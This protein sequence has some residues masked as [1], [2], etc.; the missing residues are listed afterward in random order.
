[1][2]QNHP[3]VPLHRPYNADSSP[4]GRRL[5]VKGKTAP[6]LEPLQDAEGIIDALN[7]AM[8]FEGSPRKRVLSLLHDFQKLLHRDG[9]PYDMQLILHN[10][11]TRKEGPMIVERIPTGPVLDRIEPRP[12]SELQLVIDSA[13]PVARMIIPEA[14]NHVRTPRAYIVSEDL[15]VTYRGWWEREI[16]GRFLR[17][18]GWTDLMIAVWASGPDSMLGLT[19]YG[20]EGMPRFTD[21]E[22]RLSSLMLRAAAP[23]LYREF[24]D[25]SFESLPTRPIPQQE[26][27]RTPRWDPMFGHELSERQRDVLRLLLRGLS[28]KEAANEL[29]VS[30]HTVHTHVKRLYA[31]FDVSSRGELLALFV[32]R[33]LLDAA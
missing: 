7:A 13:A 26:D 20:R 12:D 27:D 4:G 1:M 21:R 2:S 29:G 25:D 31:E 32:D 18:Q 5:V 22:K 24:F 30:G 17:P 28:E 11:L 9:E 10:Q 6:Q 23:M 3:L 14:I 16:V 19:S 33:R 15:P 8:E